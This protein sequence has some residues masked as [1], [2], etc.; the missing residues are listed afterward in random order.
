MQSERR[1]ILTKEA[2]QILGVSEAKV[3]SLAKKGVLISWRLGGSYGF[4]LENVMA[5]KEKCHS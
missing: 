1:V 3:R 4:A 5:Y 2:A